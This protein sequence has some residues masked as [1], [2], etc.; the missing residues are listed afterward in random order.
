MTSVHF[1][2]VVGVLGDWTGTFG[3]YNNDICPLATSTI[4]NIFQTKKWNAW[5]FTIC[6]H[7]CEP[8][9]LPLY[10]LQKLAKPGK[11]GWQVRGIAIHLL[12][13]NPN[14]NRDWD[15]YPGKPSPF[16]AQSYSSH[17]DAFPLQAFGSE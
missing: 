12:N 1:E 15:D 17:P 11:T 10:F 5:D 6:A 7:R 13:L 9:G 2:E 4:L 14:P 16:P 8:G 3:T